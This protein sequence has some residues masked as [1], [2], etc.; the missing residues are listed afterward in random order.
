LTKDIVV[1]SNFRQRITDY[2]ARLT[3]WSDY[4]FGEL[5]FFTGEFRLS[6]ISR[7]GDTN[8][9]YSSKLFIVL[10][11]QAHDTMTSQPIGLQVCEWSR[12][13]LESGQSCFWLNCGYMWN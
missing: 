2:S 10:S 4:I 12:V 5:T 11:L 6:N 8:I 13:I 1:I 3:Q 7:Y 9:R